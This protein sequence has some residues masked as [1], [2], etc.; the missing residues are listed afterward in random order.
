MRDDDYRG[1]IKYDQ[2]IYKEIPKLGEL[3]NLKNCYITRKGDELKEE[4]IIKDVKTFKDDSGKK[5]IVVIC[6]DKKGNTEVVLNGT[7]R[8]TRC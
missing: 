1:S 3:K 8:V 6:L 7:Y 4:Y 5:R 2:S